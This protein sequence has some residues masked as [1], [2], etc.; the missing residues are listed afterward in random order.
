MVRKKESIWSLKYQVAIMPCDRLNSIALQYLSYFIYSLSVEDFVCSLSPNSSLLL[1]KHVRSK[2]CG[3]N[4]TS[5][6]LWWRLLLYR[7]LHLLK[8]LL[9]CGT[10]AHDVGSGLPHC[11]HSRRWRRDHHAC[12]LLLTLAHDIAT[13]LLHRGNART[14]WLHSLLLLGR[15]ALVWI[16]LL[17][18]HLLLLRRIIWILRHHSVVHLGITSTHD[19]RGHHFVWLYDIIRSTIRLLNGFRVRHIS[20][21]DERSSRLAVNGC[22]HLHACMVLHTDITVSIN[23]LVSLFRMNNDRLIFHLT[24]MSRAFPSKTGLLWFSTLPCAKRGHTVAQD[25]D[26]A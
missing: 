7:W 9:W 17:H 15:I 25:T 24:N 14:S 6:Y 4:T 11:L 22:R 21:C 10:W 19:R 1:L 13:G 16:H 18:R 3:S 26:A 2:I 5:H 12:W 20:A 8:G 23:G